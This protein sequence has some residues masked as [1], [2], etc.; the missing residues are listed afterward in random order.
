MKHQLLNSFHN[1]DF[2]TS[3]FFGLNTIEET[4]GVEISIWCIKIGIVLLLHFKP[5]GEASAGG[6]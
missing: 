6:L 5:Y 3:K 1:F 4:Y 2:R